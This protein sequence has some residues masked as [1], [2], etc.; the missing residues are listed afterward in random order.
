M[1]VCMDVDEFTRVNVHERIRRETCPF[2]NDKPV[3]LARGQSHAKR[4]SETIIH[5]R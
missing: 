4:D 2:R 5:S 1:V 3:L